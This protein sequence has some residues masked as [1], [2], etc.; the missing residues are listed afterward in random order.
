M[1]EGNRQLTRQK[2]V[3]ISIVVVAI[4]LLITIVLLLLLAKCEDSSDTSSGNVIEISGEELIRLSSVDAEQS[5][6]F[7][8][9]NMFPGDRESKTYRI[10]ILNG[11][12]QAVSFRTEI[13]SEKADLSEVL[14]VS[15][16]VN[17]AENLLYAGPLKSIPTSLRA[18]MIDG[19][20]AEFMITAVLDTSVGNE[21]QAGELMLDFFWWV[22]DSD[23]IVN[24]ATGEEAGDGTGNGGKCCPWCFGI[25]PWCWI[26]LIILVVALL[27][28]IV[29]LIV[30]MIRRKNEDP[31]KTTE[32]IVTGALD[33]LEDG[34]DSNA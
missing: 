6:R 28:A 30:R 29:I 9:E 8:L 15:I 18:E 34:R 7:V 23:Y 12:V 24:D 10:E 20:E 16:A 19:N 21:Y 13:T 11:N 3:T 32:N 31:A 25:C 27:I 22:E 33:A 4:L 14:V 1:Q 5:S 2:A 17:N 26:L